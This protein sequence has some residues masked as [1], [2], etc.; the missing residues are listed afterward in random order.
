MFSC[1]DEGHIPYNEAEMEHRPFTTLPFDLGVVEAAVVARDRL[2]VRTYDAV[3]QVTRAGTVT[4]LHTFGAQSS[5]AYKGL[6]FVD[7]HLFTIDRPLKG[8]PVLTEIAPDAEA[9]RHTQLALRHPVGL[10]V[11]WGQP[12]VLDAQSP[13]TQILRW[14]QGTAQVMEE[15]RNLTAW[16][17]V[18]DRLHFS[19]ASGLHQLHQDG[20]RTMMAQPGVLNFDQDG[21]HVTQH[22]EDGRAILTVMTPDGPQRVTGLNR[23]VALH[24]L[25][26]GTFV[27]FGNRIAPVSVVADLHELPQA[28]DLGTV[29]EL[30]GA[31]VYLDDDRQLRLS[32]DT[33]HRECID[34]GVRA[35]ELVPAGT[36]DLVVTGRRGSAWVST[37]PP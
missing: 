16:K 37:L 14:D 31:L 17:Q 21:H 10:A 1:T 8:V 15:A 12:V 6:V 35:S 13:V 20:L 27:R 24:R 11:D 36:S 23:P 28:S 25:S 26:A 30:S 2:Y 3:A 33:L 9:Q 5:L 18:G 22:V 19:D 32:A 34:P 29:T 7:G 4:V